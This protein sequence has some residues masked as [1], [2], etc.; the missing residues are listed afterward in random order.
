M[1]IWL[2]MMAFGHASWIKPIDYIVLKMSLFILIQ[3]YEHQMLLYVHMQKL[4]ESRITKC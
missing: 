1:K 4:K 2:E 3:L